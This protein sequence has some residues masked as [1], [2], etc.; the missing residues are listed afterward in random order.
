MNVGV[1]WIDK[2]FGDGAAYHIWRHTVRHSGYFDRDNVLRGVGFTDDH[3]ILTV[4]WTCSAI[5]AARKLA[6]AYKDSHPAWS[7]QCAQDAVT[8][9]QGVED[10]M[11]MTLPDGSIGYLY[12]NRRYFITFGWWANPI[13]SITASGWVIF[14]DFHYNPF[15][16][17][18]GPEFHSKT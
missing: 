18:G 2:H 7:K 9:R 8:M 6:E 5:L 13:P 12:A 10:G 1:E 3:R 14:T 15:E 11:K 16:L 17:G 4:E